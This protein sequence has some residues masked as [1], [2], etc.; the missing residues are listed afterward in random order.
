M[1]DKTGP[2]V[3]TCTNILKGDS[4]K[5]AYEKPSLAKAGKLGS[6]VASISSKPAP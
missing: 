1:F 4:V 3:E 6:V 2:A 5:K